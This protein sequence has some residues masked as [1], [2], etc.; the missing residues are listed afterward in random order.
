MPVLF[1]VFLQGLTDFRGRISPSLVNNSLKRSLKEVWRC[2]YRTSLTEGVNSVWLKT[3]FV[4]EERYFSTNWWGIW[5]AF[6]PRGEG[7]WTSQSSKV[8]ASSWLVHYESLYQIPHPHLSLLLN[9]PAS[10]KI[11][12][13]W[14]K[15]P[16]T[17]FCSLKSPK[18]VNYLFSWLIDMLP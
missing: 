17:Y 16:D 1:F 12:K 8:K 15:V 18:D 4:F 14:R 10:K 11:R 7:I 6:L 2:H 3:K 5:T 9:Q 13:R